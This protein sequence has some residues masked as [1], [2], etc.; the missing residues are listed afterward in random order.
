MLTALLILVVLLIALLAVPV[1]FEIDVSGENEFRGHIMLIWA[2]GLL[3]VKI[4]RFPRVAKSDSKAARKP[5]EKKPARK[6]RKSG[7]SIQQAIG[8][9]EF[10]RRILR[11]LRDFWRAVHK[12]GLRLHLRLGLD[13]PANTGLLWAVLG[14]LSGWL[15]TLRE[16][17]VW[18]EPEFRGATVALDSAGRIWF[19]PLRLLQLI[20]GLVLSPT[21]WRGMKSMGSRS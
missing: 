12:D 5:R 20:L 14:P 2:F 3:R 13:D 17:S 11:F 18:L 15:M 4:A 19:V 10:R 16:A 21:F 1:V 9:A 7:G 8:N 6:S